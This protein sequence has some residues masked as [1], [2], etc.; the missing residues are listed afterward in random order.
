[1]PLKLSKLYQFLL[2]KL[3]G[4]GIDENGTEFWIGRKVFTIK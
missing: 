3:A 1:M 2:L 4:W